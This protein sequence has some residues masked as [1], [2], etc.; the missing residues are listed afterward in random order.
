MKP[1][2]R[3]TIGPTSKCGLEIL[4]ESLYSF[5]KIY[6][7]IDRIICYNQIEKPKIKNGNFYEQKYNELGYPL[8]P[9]EK[10]PTELG[11]VLGGMAGSGWKLTPARLRISS[12]ELWI[13]NDIIIHKKIPEIDAWIQSNKCLISEGL[14]RHYGEI[15]YSMIQENLKIC[16]GFFG[17]PPFFDFNKQIMKYVKFLNGKTL[18]SYDEQGL[19]TTVITNNDYI[20][21]PLKEMAIIE[22]NQTLQDNTSAFHFV[23]ANRTENHAGWQKYKSLKIKQF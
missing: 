3:W 4:K 22:P 13:D 21:V 20:V 9:G 15:F 2:A 10:N 1:L 11:R 16:A 12:H 6:P 17:L 5:S 19:V 8:T 23:G 7:D 14:G 18:G